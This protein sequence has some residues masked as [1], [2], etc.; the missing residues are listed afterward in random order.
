MIK[1]SL[2]IY[3]LSSSLFAVNVNLLS[4]SHSP[5]YML[6]EDTLS[7]NSLPNETIIL[8][9][10][11][12]YV[13][14]PFIE[15]NESRTERTGTLVE[16]IN[17]LHMGIGYQASNRFLLGVSTFAAQVWLPDRTSEYS[18]GDTVIIGKYRLSADKNKTSFAL[19]PELELPTGNQQLFLSNNGV[20]VGLK[21]AVE[22]DFGRFQ[23]NGNIGYKVNN[24]A[25]YRQLDYR[26]RLLLAMGALYNLNDQWALSAEGTTTRT[27][28][29][30]GVNN[31]GEFYF[32][33]RY[34]P[35]DKISFNTGISIGNLNSVGS[36]EFRLLAGVKFIPKL[37][38][39]PYHWKHLF[40]KEEQ[41]IIRK[42]LEIR[43]E[44]QFE[45]DSDKLTEAGRKSLQKIA[46]LILEGNHEFKQIVIEGHT[47]KLGA[48]EYNYK[49]SQNRALQVRE[50]LLKLGLKKS[51]VETKAYGETRPKAI[52][53]WEIAKKL[54]RRVEFKVLK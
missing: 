45:H 31:P 38:N 28:P 13:E 9:S 40:T 49:L 44:I 20:G 52:D 18:L 37:K 36:N 35:N 8:S 33:G 27:L 32:G 10:Y 43:D 1:L 12:N 17:S 5:V 54:N 51:L 16:G 47:N 19:I 4:H 29:F 48:K 11:Y 14:D 24:K 21:L 3:L 7:K 41:E 2:L 25:K 39:G 22:Q 15:M 30:N 42:I 46:N 23:L 50:E 34:H 53:Q 26:Q 6:T